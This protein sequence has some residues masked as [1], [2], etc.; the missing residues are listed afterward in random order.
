LQR[1]G[2]FLTEDQAKYLLATSLTNLAR[3][4]Y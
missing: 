4:T 1:R 2:V 3:V